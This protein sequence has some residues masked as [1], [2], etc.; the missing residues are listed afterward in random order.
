MITGAAQADAAILVVP[1]TRGEFEGGFSEDG[2]IREHAVLARS[3]GV[4]QLILA[5][6]KLDT[7]GWAA[8]RYHEIVRIMVPYL[9]S[10]GYK[11]KDIQ[12]VPV[13]GLTGENILECK[14]PALKEWYT[15]PVLLELID[16]F[17][18]PPRQEDRPMRLCV[19]DVFRTLSLGQAVAGKVECGTILPRDR[20]LLLP[21]GETLTV[22][23][24]ESR[25]EG[26]NI[27]RAGD[28]VELGVRD[29]SDP[30]VLQ[31]GQWL[32]DPLHPIPMVT[33]FRAQIITMN[34]RVPL[35]AG[36]QLT[37]YTQACSEPIVLKSLMSIVDKV[38]GAVVKRNPRVLPREST[39]VV[40]LT[41]RNKI[42]L[43]LFKNYRQ[44]GRFSLRRGQDTVA[45]GVVIKLYRMQ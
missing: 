30:A 9:K 21:L 42:C 38:T 23:A 17:Q 36:S 40:E 43:E 26:L 41:A 16:R 15:G 22:R 20:L 31:V 25:G 37:F 7:C 14:E 33:H 11:E 27:A 32:C 13:S 45:V 44:L 2:Q 5:V 10:V 34:Y 1:A 8:E 28:N 39:A 6:N 24:L 18:L 19:Q 35:L 29:F 3:L 12:P 4:A